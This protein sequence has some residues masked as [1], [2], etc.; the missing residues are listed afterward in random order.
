[1]SSKSCQAKE[2]LS[3]VEFWWHQRENGTIA[4]P[5]PL[6]VAKDTVVLLLRLFGEVLSQRMVSVTVSGAAPPT[7]SQ[8]AA[9]NFVVLV[10]GGSLVCFPWSHP[11]GMPFPP[12][13]EQVLHCCNISCCCCRGEGKIALVINAWSFYGCSQ[14]IT[15]CDHRNS[16]L[17]Q[18]IR[19]KMFSLRYFAFENR[20]KENPS[21]FHLLQEI[22]SWAATEGCKTEQVPCSSQHSNPETRLKSLLWGGSTSSWDEGETIWSCNLPRCPLGRL[23][24]GTHLWASSGIN[25]GAFQSSQGMAPSAFHC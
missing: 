5:G 16:K 10:E 23:P 21:F 8:N 13:Q 25:H 4:M 22:C 9:P 14:D 7:S 19:S 12:L 17:S 11:A 18:A 15:F 2:T 1:M 3:C 24:V 20:N 6:P